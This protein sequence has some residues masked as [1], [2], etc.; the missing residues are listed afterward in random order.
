MRAEHVIPIGAGSWTL[1]VHTRARWQ[2]QQVSLS[3]SILRARFLSDAH[4]FS[5]SLFLSLSRLH[6][7]PPLCV[8]IERSGTKGMH[9]LSALSPLAQAVPSLSVQDRGHHEYTPELYSK[10]GRSLSV[11]LSRARAHTHFLS[12]VHT[13]SLSHTHTHTLSLSLS[14]FLSL[15]LSLALSLGLTTCPRCVCGSSVLGPTA[16]TSFAR[17]PLQVLLPLQPTTMMFLL[18]G[19]KPENLK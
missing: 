16:G 1:R 12:H 3:L 11:S 14:L 4:T 8:R 7:E 2:K 13:F 5:L 17:P 18:I 15:F 9:N 6:D 10:S 19:V